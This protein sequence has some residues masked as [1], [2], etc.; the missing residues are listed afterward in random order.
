MT[1]ERGRL[2][3]EL[4]FDHVAIVAVCF[5]CLLVGEGEGVYFNEHKMCH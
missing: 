5:V 2:F 4:K 1:V 3:K